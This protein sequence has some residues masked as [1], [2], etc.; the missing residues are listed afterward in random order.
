M[1]WVLYGEIPENAQA[2]EIVNETYKKNTCV[3]LLLT[4][5]K[6]KYQIV[7][8]RQHTQWKNKVVISKNGHRFGEKDSKVEFINKEIIFYLTKRGIYAKKI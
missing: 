8:Y 2:D 7:R 5:G 3:R 4:D 6:D 1:Y